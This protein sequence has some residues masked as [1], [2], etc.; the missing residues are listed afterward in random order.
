L[1]IHVSQIGESFVEELADIE[2]KKVITTPKP[3]RS[4]NNSKHA[5]RCNDRI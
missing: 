2:N 3:L 5:W 1:Q 4:K